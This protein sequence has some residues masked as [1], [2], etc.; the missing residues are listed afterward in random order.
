MVIFKLPNDSSLSTILRFK[1]VI[2]Y[3]LKEPSLPG[4]GAKD[5]VNDH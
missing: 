3:P 4:A 2:T 5:M 1:F